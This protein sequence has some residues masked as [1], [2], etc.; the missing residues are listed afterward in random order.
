MLNVPDTFILVHTPQVVAV[1]DTIEQRSCIRVFQFL[2]QRLLS[3]H[4]DRKDPVV[5]G[6]LLA[7]QM[8][9]REHILMKEITFIDE[10]CV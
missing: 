2:K 6:V 3:A 9:L 4:D 8:K 1:K 10:K 7:E 5:I